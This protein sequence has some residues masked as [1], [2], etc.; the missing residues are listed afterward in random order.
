MRRTTEFFQW[1]LRNIK[2]F[3]LFSWIRKTSGLFR[4]LFSQFLTYIYLGQVSHYLF[5]K[6]ESQHETELWRNPSPSSSGWSQEAASLFLAYPPHP[7]FFAP[8]VEITPINLIAFPD[9][10][11]YKTE[12]LLP[13][14]SIGITY[15]NPKPNNQNL[16]LFRTHTPFLCDMDVKHLYT[17]NNAWSSSIHVEQPYTEWFRLEKTF[18][19]SAPW[20]P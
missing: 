11:R 14:L 4:G 15:K 7:I 18:K 17:L 1:I 3:L 9:L 5:I 19:S 13:Q 20:M 16:T 2:H 12:F 8:C 10:F 6:H